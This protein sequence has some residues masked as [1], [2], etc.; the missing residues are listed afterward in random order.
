MLLSINAISQK[1][2]LREKILDPV[3]ITANKIEQKQSKNLC[4]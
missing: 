1:D 3:I 4:S 2:T